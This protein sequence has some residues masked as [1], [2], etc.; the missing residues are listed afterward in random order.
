MNIG[1]NLFSLRN[2]LSGER[3][4]LEAVKSLKEAGYDYFQF[5]GAPF[6]AEMIA[7]VGKEAGVPFY[8][9][10]VPM[11]RILGDTDALMREHELFGCRNIGLGMMPKELL[12]DGEAFRRKVDELERAAE[13][14]EERGFFFFYHHHH[15]EFYKID[16]EPA[17]DYMLKNTSHIRFT[18]DTYWL[19]Y[20][21][22]DVLEY[23]GKMRG[24]VD[25]V[26]LKDYKIV[27]RDEGKGPVMVPE[28]A[29]LGDG[30]M[31]LP[32]V[33]RKARESGTKYFFVEQDNA[34]DLPDGFEQVARSAAYAGKEL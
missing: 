9:T 27:I 19:Q 6:D 1:L 11:E 14:M 17:L 13:R 10:H 22:A 28:F 21:G 29:A 5:S 4:F 15:F 25:C 34:A 20:G 2:M 12:L 23:L 18:A 3:A 30:V 16:G 31:D 26:H 7:R 8:L 32:A 24:R 33:V